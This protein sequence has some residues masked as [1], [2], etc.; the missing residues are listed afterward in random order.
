MGSTPGDLGE[1][2]DGSEVFH[3]DRGDVCDDTHEDV[4]RTK[5]NQRG[6][7]LQNF[8]EPHSCDR[9]AAPP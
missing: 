4:H 2:F 1:P 3:E 9:T 6:V 8:V 7:H 5:V